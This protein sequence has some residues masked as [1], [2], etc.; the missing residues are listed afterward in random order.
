MFPT[1]EEGRRQAYLAAIGIPL[2]TARRPLPH[3]AEADSLVHSPFLAEDDYPEEELADIPTDLRAE[4]GAT[5][6][7]DGE[8]DFGDFPEGPPDDGPPLDA[9]LDDPDI[10]EAATR[11]PQSGLAL[12]RQLRQPES[13]A[14]TAPPVLTRPQPALDT[15]DEDLQ[16]VH[17]QFSLFPCGRTG[18]IVP[19]LSLLSPSEDRL[20]G[21][22]LQALTGARAAPLSFLWPVVNNHAIP[23]HRRAAREALGGFLGQQGKGVSA[24][25]VLGEHETELHGLLAA[26]TD[27]P[28][29][30]VP[31]LAMMLQQP[32]R[33]RDVW[34][35]LQA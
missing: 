21:N 16:P 30:P 31:G 27:R 19:R 8:E 7:T 18:L 23:R 1:G 26:S 20:L 13:P 34:L 32:M 28:V 3:A 9:Y 12:S 6:D 22:L 10:R 2:W 33:K 25:V 11:G 14:P 29:R 35:A 15:P 5:A 4:D 17:F 24:F